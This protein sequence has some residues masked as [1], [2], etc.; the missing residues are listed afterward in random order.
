MTPAAADWIY[1]EVLTTAY[2]RSVGAEGR[3]DEEMHLGPAAVRDCRC[4]WGPCGH[5]Q[6]GRPDRC[7]HRR[8]TAPASL[9]D[10]HVLGRD[11]SV[12]AGWRRV[13]T[14]CVW[15]C[16]GPPG[17]DLLFTVTTG[18]VPPPVRPERLVSAKPT[19]A[20]QLDLFAVGGAR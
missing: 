8:G 7:A 13:G 10:G 11:G 9:H 4:Q 1:R 16:P 15:R 6:A 19:P 3:G 14:V 20:E 18:A 5:C 12:R 2:R 17:G